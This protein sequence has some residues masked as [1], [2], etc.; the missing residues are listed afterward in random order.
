[1]GEVPDAVPVDNT[2]R[3]AFR[4]RLEGMEIALSRE[5]QRR[6]QAEE[7][8]RS[9]RSD[10]ID[11]LVIG[12][13]H[14]D[15]RHDNERF[16]WLGRAIV[17]LQPDVVVDIGDWAEMG[18]LSSYDPIHKLMQEGLRLRDD[19][20]VAVDARQQVHAELAAFNKGRKR[21]YRPELLAAL[22]NHEQRIV[23]AI[24]AEPQR[25]DGLVHTK[26]LGA[27]DFG[28]TVFP[29]LEPFYVAGVAFS[30]CWPKPG[31]RGMVT[32]VNHGRALLMHYHQTMVQG[33]SHTLFAHHERRADGK[34][35][36]AVGVGGYFSHD[37]EWVEPSN[38]SRWWRGLTQLKGVADGEIAAVVPIPLSEVQARWS[39]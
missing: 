14:A 8:A 25:Y 1:M 26:D 2:E 21:K 4:Q 3:R 24:D 18:S 17:E 12:D 19:I 35:L 39:G 37:P 20:D 7:L 31:G 36:T 16:T 23:R 38:L 10:P 33:H 29:Y 13:A 22:G 27:E 32:G 11:I 30:H 15:P 28:W 5:R 34:R 6:A 9:V